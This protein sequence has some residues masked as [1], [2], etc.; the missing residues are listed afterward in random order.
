[1]GDIYII[2]T[3]WPDCQLKQ[4]NSTHLESH[5]IGIWEKIVTTG[6]RPP[7]LSGHTLTM[8]DASHAVLFGG[9]KEDGSCVNDAYILSM[10]SWVRMSKQ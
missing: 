6:N 2:F 10:D 5:I 4:T 7:Q 1:M 9:Q 8:T 3:T